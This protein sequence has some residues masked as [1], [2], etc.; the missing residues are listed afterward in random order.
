MPDWQ[1]LIL[2]ICA[3]LIVIGAIALSNAAQSFTIIRGK[4]LEKG[5]AAVDHNCNPFP[6]QTVSVLLES[7]DRVFRIERGTVVKYAISDTDAKLVDVGAEVELFI[8]SYDGHARM[9]PL[10]HHF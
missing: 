9:L 4:V 5:N 6:T 10:K 8:S 3:M 2:I 1:D 7:N